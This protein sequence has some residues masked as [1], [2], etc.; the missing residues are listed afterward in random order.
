MS[1][2][3]TPRYSATTPISSPL[4]LDSVGGGA[5]CLKSKITYLVLDVFRFKCD[6]SHQLTK[7]FRTGPCLTSSCSNRLTNTMSSTNLI[8]WC[9]GYLLRQQSLFKIYSQ[10]DSILPCG[11]PI[12]I[13]CTSDV[14]LLNLG[15][16][17]IRK[18][19]IIN[20]WSGMQ[21]L[22]VIRYQMSLSLK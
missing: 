4:I 3:I 1:S 13:K 10:G 6:A 2:I 11:V 9:P 15:D 17:P 22:Y 19:K 14:V 8:T 5:S 20:S 21:P 16:L 18:S 7:S 12:E